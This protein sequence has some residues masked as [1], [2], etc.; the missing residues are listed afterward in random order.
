MIKSNFKQIV[1]L[2][3]GYLIHGI[4]HSEQRIIVKDGG[5]VTVSI[6]QYAATEISIA[7]DR[8]LNVQWTS[9]N[10][11]HKKDEKKGSIKV[12]PKTF[13]IEP[14]QVNLTTEKRYRVKLVLVPANIP[15]DKVACVIEENPAIAS[16]WE[17]AQPYEK[18]ITNLIKAMYSQSILSGFSI[19][20]TEIRQKKLNQL[21]VLSYTKYQGDKIW[22]E[23]WELANTT[24]K[25]I[26]LID[27]DFSNPGVR[28]IAI[29]KKQL[30]PKERTTLFRVVSHD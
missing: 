28:A 30:F 25:T 1:F 20:T 4:V 12:Q 11:E 6:S 9:E 16:K 29:E 8:I 13:D 21:A 17:Q 24:G 3:V 10:L 22:G 19:D 26:T 18:V 2:L 7:N 14:M 23:R 15:P 27:V 5:M